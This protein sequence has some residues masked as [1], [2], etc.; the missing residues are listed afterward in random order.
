MEKK[1]TKGISRGA[2]SMNKIENLKYFIS[3][4]IVMSMQ[5]RQ[6][7]FAGSRKS[8]SKSACHGTRASPQPEQ[9][10]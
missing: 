9:M 2:I 10:T 5:P 4:E 7:R 8:G 1:L 6:L 3:G